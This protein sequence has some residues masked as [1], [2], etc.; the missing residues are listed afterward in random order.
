MAS[1]EER[2]EVE[3]YVPE[4]IVDGVRKVTVL[5]PQPD[6]WPEEPFVD[7]MN[8]VDRAEPALL[9]GLPIL[10]TGSPGAGKT[11]VVRVLAERWGAPVFSCQG[12]GDLSPTDLGC[13]IRLDVD[14]GG[15]LVASPLVC[16]L[17]KG[18]VF[19]FD[20]LT[21]APE[22]SLALLASVLDGRKSLDSD[23]A[24]I[25]IGRAHPRFRMF[26]TANAADRELSSWIRTRLPVKIAVPLPNAAQLTVIVNAHFSGSAYNALLE[27]FRA[28]GR[29][30]DGLAPRTAISMIRWADGK[31]RLMGGASLSPAGA[32]R[33]IEEAAALIVEEGA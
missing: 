10:L 4:A 3:G 11:S 8:I 13:K 17:L 28:W 30:R 20:E 19:L 14:P 9:S 31:R 29:G 6:V 1:S 33:L 18:S 12:H 7:V 5:C 2:A 21:R 24:G 32:R 26:A 15:R 23:I 16:A 25:K 27:A 22:R